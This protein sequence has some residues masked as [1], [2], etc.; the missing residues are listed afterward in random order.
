MTGAE[1]GSRR[2]TRRDQAVLEEHSTQ[3]R[4]MLRV[5]LRMKCLLWAP[6]STRPIRFTAAISRA[7]SVA[8]NAAKSGA[9]R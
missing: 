9:S 1:E 8:T 5:L 3:G 2:T 7:L 4:V 6:H